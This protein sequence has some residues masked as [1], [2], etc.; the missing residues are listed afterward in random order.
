MLILTHLQSVSHLPQ[1][2]SLM[3]RSFWFLFPSRASI[4]NWEIK[5]IINICSINGGTQHMINIGYLSVRS[6]FM[7]LE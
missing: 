6:G 1:S 7:P 5:T 2:H 4:L 3:M